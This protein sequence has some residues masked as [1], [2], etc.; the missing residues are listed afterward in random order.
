MGEVDA[1]IKDLP[2]LPCRLA[3]LTSCDALSEKSELLGNPKSFCRL[4]SSS[5]F[6]NLQEEYKYVESSENAN[7]SVL[8]EKGDLVESYLQKAQKDILELTCPQFTNYETSEYGEHSYEV[9][10]TLV[11][12]ALKSIARNKEGRLTMPLFW[13]EKVAHLLAKN[14]HLAEIILKANFK[15]LHKSNRLQLVDAVFKEQESMGIIERVNNLEQYLE[16]NPN[17]SFLPH[18]PVFR[19]NRETTKCRVVF[20]K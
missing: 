5:L 1:L 7:F 16:E 10:D 4:G 19:L 17:S 18:M 6:L 9:N 11:A 12:F 14:R 8:N 3:T 13:N 15:K 2:Y 20:F